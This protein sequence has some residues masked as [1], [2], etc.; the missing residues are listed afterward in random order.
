[1]KE[2][3]CEKTIEVCRGLY[4][5]QICPCC[6]KRL[7]DITMWAGVP[8]IISVKC[9]Y[10]RRVARLKLIDTESAKN[11]YEFH[12]DKTPIKIECPECHKRILDTSRSPGAHAEIVLKCP[13]CQQVVTLPVNQVNHTGR[14][15]LVAEKITY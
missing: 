3:A 5:S 2:N 14:K 13:H 15:L 7:M 4:H 9:P 8:F 10:C 6:Q 11:G 1:M 12:Q